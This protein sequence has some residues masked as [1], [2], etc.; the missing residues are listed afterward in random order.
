MV[1]VL[2]IEKQIAIINALE[3]GSSIRQIE[4]ITDNPKQPRK[5]GTVLHITPV[6]SAVADVRAAIVQESRDSESAEAE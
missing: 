6:T 5:H 4:G 1:N 3:E 2:P